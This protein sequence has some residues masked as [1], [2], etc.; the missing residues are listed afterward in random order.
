MYWCALQMA[1]TELNWF[2]R[3]LQRVEQELQAKEQEL[4]EVTMADGLPAL[5]AL[6]EKER[7]RLISKKKDLRQQLSALQASLASPASEVLAAPFSEL[8]AADESD[9]VALKVHKGAARLLMR[10]AQAADVYIA[11]EG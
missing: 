11:G 10:A 9:L 2:K 3:E 4:R 7:D 8:S 6:I 5:I 1:Q